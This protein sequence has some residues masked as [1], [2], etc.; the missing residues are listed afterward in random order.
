MH[1]V[2]PY[3]LWHSGN[4]YTF[5]IHDEFDILETCYLMGS[6]VLGMTK[7]ISNDPAKR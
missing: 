1:I 5:F 7:A 4:G 2:L 3:Q 6:Y